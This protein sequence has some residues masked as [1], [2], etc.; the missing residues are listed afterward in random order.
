MFDALL[1]GTGAFQKL[2]QFNIVAVQF[3]ARGSLSPYGYKQ[4]QECQGEDGYLAW[5]AHLKEVAVGR[6]RYE[7][8]NE[9]LY[10]EVGL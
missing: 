6:R 9:K 5:G 2:A 7:C 3:P 1:L 10:D 4:Q 8:E